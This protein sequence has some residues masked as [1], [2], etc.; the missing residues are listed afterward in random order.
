MRIFVASWFFPPQTSS[1][2]IVT[3][4][5]LRNSGFEYDVVC[6][7]SLLWGYKESLEVKGGSINI[8][9]VKTDDLNVWKQKALSLFEERHAQKP[10]D[11]VMTRCMPNESLEIGLAIK[12]KHPDV[13]WINS[14]ADPVA[15]NPYW[16][17]AIEQEQG[18]DCGTRERVVRELSLP[19]ELWTRDWLNDLKPTIRNQFYWKDVQDRSI[20]MADMVLTPSAEQRNYMAPKEMH[21]KFLVLPHAYD[22]ELYGQA[23]GAEDWERDKVHFLFTG[24]ADNLRSL[25]PFVDAAKWIRGNAPVQLEQ[26]RI[27]FYGNYSD[28]LIDRA[29]AFEVQDA[30]DFQGN[31]PYSWSLALMEQADWLLHVDAWFSR[32]NKT[33]GSIFFA[34]KLADYMGSGRPIFALTGENSP[35]GRIV[36]QYGGR[37]LL[38]WETEAIAKA[39]LNALNDRGGTTINEGYRAAYDAR[40]VAADFD[41]AVWNMV[42]EQ[43]RLPKGV[44]RMGEMH[45]RAL[46]VC[47]P[48]YNAEKTLRR[49]LDSLLKI[50]HADKLQVIIVDDGSKDGTADIGQA[51]VEKYPDSVMMV[52]KENGGHGSGINRGIEYACGAYFRV[53]DSDDWVDSNAL[54]AQIEYILGTQDKPDVIYTPHFIV[55]QATGDRTP[56]PSPGKAEARRVYTFDEAIDELGLENVYFTMAATSFRTEILKNMGLRLREKCFYTDSEFILKP[57]VHVNTAVFLPDAVYR[58]LRGQAEQSVAPLSFVRHYADHESVVRELITYERQTQMSETQRRYMRHILGQHLRTNYQILLGFDPNLAH[59]LGCMKRFDE[60]LREHAPDYFKWTQKNMKSV[61]AVR[62]VHYRQSCAR[63]ILSRSGKAGRNYKATIRRVGSSVLHSK[64]FVNR[65]TGGFI[66]RTRENNG[67]LYRMYQKVR[68]TDGNWRNKNEL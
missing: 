3:Y 31:I 1:E 43:S 4:K 26:I 37:I 42:N 27:H 64:L 60:W 46:T 14:L 52:S 38:P 16:I 50:E 11:A 7:D 36:S 62:A 35:A 54:N 12:E 67:F 6:A 17:A 65:F 44:V 2:G 34:G 33:G 58:Y 22:R 45:A 59:G 39:I 56:W 25:R 66:I 55:D 41:A 30:F 51:Y 32:L 40:R 53:V 9:P 47:V 24:Y 68:T 23:P 18:L 28:E 19:R 29:M 21:S 48:S 10:F 20:R 57:I 15:N 63:R 8:V 61:A 13:K 49:T 5:L